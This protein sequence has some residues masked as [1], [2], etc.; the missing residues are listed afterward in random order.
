MFLQIGSECTSL[1]DTRK[2][3]P[4]EAVETEGRGRPYLALADGGAPAAT[5]PVNRREEMLKT[6]TMC[7]ALVGACVA[8]GIAQ[9]ADEQLKHTGMQKIDYPGDKNLDRAEPASLQKSL[10]PCGPGRSGPEAT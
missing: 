3:V 2:K 7:A 6:V 5:G 1:R 10:S 9:L 8:A 4:A